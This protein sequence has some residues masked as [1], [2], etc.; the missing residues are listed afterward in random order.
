[1]KFI[2]KL[3][4][5][6]TIKSKPV[7]KRLVR[8]LRQ[9]VQVVLLKE[10]EG[11]KVQEF[12]DKLEVRL[13]PGYEN[14]EAKVVDALQRI[15]GISNVLKVDSYELEGIDSRF[16]D[17]A[18]ICA[19]TY[20]EQIKG[21]TF[22]VR[23]KRA[24][25]HSFASSELERYLGGALLRSCE[26]ESVSL[27]QPDVTVKLEVRDDTLYTV[28]ERYEGLGGFPIGTQEPVLSLISGGFDSTVSSY[29]TMKRG[30][31]THFC[32]FN[33]GGDAHEI[34]VKQVSLYLWEKYGRSHRVHFI[35]VPFEG[36]VGEIL[37]HVNHSHM[38]VVLKR[39]MVRAAQEIAKKMD[40]T[41]L[42][43]GE[44]VAQVSSQ[45]VTN[46][47][48]IDR[49]SETVILRPLITMDK[50]DIIRLSAKIGTEEFAK[51]M[52]EYCGVISDKPTTCAKL[53]KVEEEEGNFDFSVLDQAIEDAVVKKID[54]VMHQQKNVVDVDV[55][56]LPKVGDVVIDIRGPE[57]ANKSPLTLTNNEVL[58]IPFYELMSET[59]RLDKAKRYL[60]FCE[61]GTMSQLHASHLKGMDFDTAVFKLA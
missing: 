24:G 36:V 43:T 9:N 23:V 44:S 25:E 58:H 12:W 20:G 21:K 14:D 35:S 60:L 13:L 59:E 27:K 52:P 2:V 6:I 10:T 28:S 4:P 34:G 39:M 48:V 7:R 46:L 61:K 19:D 18:Q 38:G 3:F 56:T 51:N 54:Q 30:L 16:D 5:E 33:L 53:A 42:V 8:Q 55:T 17:I 31:K 47:N 45:T 32:F 57:E 26:P 1:M 22:V 11:A 29:L 49:V 41:A 15:P 40:V 37:K 50:L